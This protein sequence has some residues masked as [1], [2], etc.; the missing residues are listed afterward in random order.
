MKLIKKSNY[1]L[2]NLSNLV[3]GEQL[4]SSFD[5]ENLD[6]EVILYQSGYLT[7]DRVETTLFESLE[8]HLKIPN[9][10]VKQ[11]LNDV[12]IKEIYN[13]HQNLIEKKTNI[14]KSLLENN[15]DNLKIS[16][17][18]IFATIP[19]N[20][21]TKNNIANYEGFYASVLY[22]YLQSLGLNIIGEDVT[23]K[24]RI[25]LTIKM[26]NAIF[27]LEFKV[28][29]KKGEALE[30]IKDKNYA[31]KYQN[32]NKDIYLIGISF[33]KKERNISGFEWQSWNPELAKSQSKK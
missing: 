10:E 5:I 13:N 15:M 31:L 18:S 28:D 21:F 20:N 1:F 23:N 3:V 29:G 17:Q 12:I 14:Y 6:L 16:L 30:Q 8:Y 9:M 19:Y 7:I 33:D 26:D 27:I 25:D 32:Q 22:V 4:L 24:G 2:P 11:S